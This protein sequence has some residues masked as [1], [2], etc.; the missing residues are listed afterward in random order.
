MPVIPKRRRHR[1]LRTGIKWGLAVFAIVFVF[2]VLVL[3]E[4]PGARKS[5]H[6]LG[7][8]NGFY[9]VA[10]VVLE[11]AALFAYA[12]LTHTVL[13]EKSPSRWRL[14]QINMSSLALS[15]IVPGGAAPGAALSYRLLTQNDVSGPDAGFAIGMQGVGSAV[16]LNVILW[17]ALL[18]SLFFHGYKNPLYGVA[19]GAGL[20]LM[21]LFASVVLLLTRGRIRSV[22]AVRHLAQRV[23]FLD[24][25]RLAEA[26]QR[27]ADRLRALAVDRRVLARAI[28]WAAANW[29]L[30]ASSLWVFIAAFGHLVSPIDLLVAYGLA[31]VLAV[32]PITPSGLGVVEGVLIATLVGFNVPKGVA[33]L[34]VVV[35]RLVNFW[36]PIPIGGG[37]Y[38]SLRFT[39]VGWRERL[40][41]AR[42]EI[43]VPRQ[44]PG[45]EER[46]PA[47]AVPGATDI[48][49]ATNGS[50][51]TGRPTGS[52]RSS[53]ESSG[54]ENAD[55]MNG[56]P[57]SSQDLSRTKGDR[58]S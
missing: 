19:A 50:K 55:K 3:P 26:V 12:Q 16:V 10:G 7:R 5:L 1:R 9:I 53:E 14:L 47:V 49:A 32:I 8:V 54:A 51:D 44:Q 57:R 34:G 46:Q 28:G 38:L 56:A 24:A 41:S 6:L 25:D 29:L 30:D 37:T 52:E 15:H 18:I 17:V 11:A 42:E 40:R 39:S 45:E 48:P 36:L 22:E 23:P 33:F 27:V 13:P 31:N 43:E 21:A 2:E 58:S 35:W 4:L 20:L